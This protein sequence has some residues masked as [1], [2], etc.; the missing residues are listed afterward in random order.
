[1]AL[2]IK[3]DEAH[4]LAKDLAEARGSSLTDAVTAALSESL[5]ASH[6]GGAGLE[7]LMAEVRQVQALVAEL[8]D[9]DPRSADEILG[10]DESGMPL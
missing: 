2:N 3:S 8:P 4:R 10:Y 9:R 5:R 6:R 1:M 7:T